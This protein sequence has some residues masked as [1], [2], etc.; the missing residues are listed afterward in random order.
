[1]QSIELLS[2]K[3]E[4]LRLEYENGTSILENRD[5]SFTSHIHS[6]NARFEDTKSLYEKNGIL[7]TK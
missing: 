2:N 5:Q 6:L 4:D 7:L 1:M 3:I